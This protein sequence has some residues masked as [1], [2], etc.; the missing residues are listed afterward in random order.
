[1]TGS[2]IEIERH[3]AAIQRVDISRPVKL[4]LEWNILTTSKSFFDYGCGYGGDV[5]RTTK[6]GYSTLR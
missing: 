3:R 2:Y 6:L 5:Q 4:A 1:M